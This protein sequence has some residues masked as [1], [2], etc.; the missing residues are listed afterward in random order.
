MKIISTGKHR[1]EFAVVLSSRS[2]QAGMM[3][4]QPGSASSDEPENEHPR[5][6]QWLFVI[7]GTGRAR[8]G[9]RTV[10]LKPNALLLI[11]KGEGHQIINTGRK[12]LRT[13]NFYSPPA[14]RKNGSPLPGREG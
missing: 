2:T 11:E 14:Y 1:K 8:V 9:R 5:S 6:E 12:P 13:I 10:A 4:L 3:I 7:G